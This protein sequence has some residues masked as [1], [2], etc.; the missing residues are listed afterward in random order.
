MGRRRRNK[1]TNGPPYKL[2]EKAPIPSSPVFHQFPNPHPMPAMGARRA[3]ARGRHAR[4][5][6]ARSPLPRHHCEVA[7]LP[8]AGAGAGDGKQQVCGDVG[9]RLAGLGRTH[10]QL[11]INSLVAT[12]SPSSSA[13]CYS[14]R[15]TQQ[16]RPQ[17][18]HRSRPGV[19]SGQAS[20][21]A[22][23]SPQA[24]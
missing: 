24:G 21:P 16:P 23:T 14:L 10:T 19:Q 2:R 4:R 3:P 22:S 12:P 13:A 8:Y 17:G 20:S 11:H 6:S 7:T 18:P 5:T 1:M 9:G 15:R